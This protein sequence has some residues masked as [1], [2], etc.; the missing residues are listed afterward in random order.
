[1]SFITF[2]WE[3][4]H[5][6]DAGLLLVKEIVETGIIKVGAGAGVITFWQ[7]VMYIYIY[8]IQ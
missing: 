7:E 1:V 8:N 4:R 5:S 2:W 3:A 6:H